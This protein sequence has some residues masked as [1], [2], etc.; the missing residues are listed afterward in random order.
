M[1]GTETGVHRSSSVSLEML[2]VQAFADEEWE[3]SQL[4]ARLRVRLHRRVLDRE[5]AAGAPL[6]S[7]PARALRALQLTGAPERRRIARCLA[8]ILEAADERHADPES[9]VTLNHADVL[10]ARHQI[11]ALIEVL[12]SEQAVAA[13]GAALARLLIVERRSPMLCESSERTVQQ[14]VSEALV[15]LQAGDRAGL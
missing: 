13:R 2:A 8:N 10:V 14:A 9:P 6:D 7:D 5:I 12:R 4:A 1:H 11:V 15:A 3:S